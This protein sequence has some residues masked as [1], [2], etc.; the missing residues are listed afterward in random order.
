LV[1]ASAA[2]GPATIQPAVTNTAKTLAK[3]PGIS[4]LPDQSC[5]AGAYHDAGVCRA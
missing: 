4:I 2:V 5:F 1:C 3:I